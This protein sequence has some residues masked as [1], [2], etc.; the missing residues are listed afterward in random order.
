[1]FCTTS[2]QHVWKTSNDGQSWERI[3]PDLTRADPKTLGD[4]GGPITKDQNGPEI[5]GTVFS[6]APSFQDENTIWTGSD[7]GMV[8]ITRNGGKSWDNITP[9]GMPE[10][11]R[12]SMIDASTHE[13]GTAY[14]A[15]KR[16][17]L[18]DRKPYIYRTHDFGKTWTSIVEGIP[19]DDYVHVTR[20][21]PGMKGLLYAGTEHGIYVSFDDGDHWQSLRLNLPDTQVFRFGFEGRRSGDCDAW[22]VVLGAGSISD[23]AS[24]DSGGGQLARPFV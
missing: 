19:L 2:S 1:M 17:Q 24:A 21:D 15:A 6:I 4:S 18:D 11:S 3:S 14:L 22:P 13:A 23:A 7:D 12:I 9:K 5:Y 10:F 8:Y 20:E 16:Y